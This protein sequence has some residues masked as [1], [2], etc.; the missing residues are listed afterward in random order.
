MKKSIKSQLF[1]ILLTGLGFLLSGPVTAQTFTVLYS[2]TANSGYPG[3]NNDGAGPGGGLTLSGNTL[4]GTAGLAGSGNNGTVFSLNT[5]GTGFTTLHSFTSV[6]NPDHFSSGT[7][8]DGANP[9]AG[10]ILSGSTLYGTAEQG[11]SGGTGT[12]FALNTNGTGFTTLYSFTAR[13]PNYTNSGSI[14]YYTNSDGA[15]PSVLILSSNT[16]YGTAGGGASGSSGSGTV[17]SLSLPIALPQLTL[18]PAGPNVI[19]T[20][21]TNAAGFNLQSTTD[22]GSSEVWTTNLPTPVIVNDQ[23]VV[24]NPISGTQM[25]FRLSQ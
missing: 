22:L 3:Y 25:S 21:P 8:S 9:Y 14:V 7:N 24:T 10:L 17:F 23:N 15:D 13:S 20:W 18:A 1:P 2:F 16:L 19:L 11:G 6:S 12:L 4:F 5:D